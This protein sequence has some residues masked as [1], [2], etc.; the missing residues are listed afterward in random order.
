MPHSQHSNQRSANTQ[1]ILLVEDNVMDVELTLAAFKECR[2]D[3]VVQVAN[4]GQAALDYLFGRGKFMDRE[5][6]P[7][8]DMILLDLKMPCID[9]FEV[10]R[11]AKTWPALRHIP[12]VVLT[13]SREQG[14][15][16]ACYN[17]G[18]NSY[19]VKPVSFH[20]FVE[21]VRQINTYWLDLNV[22]PPPETGP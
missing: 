7:L 4:G 18:A 8:P 16:L 5:L 22:P 20:G 21:L 14:D 19:L 11:Q 15:L 13:S 2:M 17:I 6:F 9:G 1:R 3:V 10:L 12:I